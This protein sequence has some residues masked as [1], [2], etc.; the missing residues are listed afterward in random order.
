MVRVILVDLAVLFEVWPGAGADFFPDVLAALDQWRG[1]G[2]AVV[3]ISTDAS[4]YGARL[5]LLAEQSVP[6][7]DQPLPRW[8]QVG[9]WHD[10]LAEM[11]QSP[12][13][14]VF[15]AGSPALMASARQAGLHA[16]G[17][18]RDPRTMAVL[19]GLW[20]DGLADISW[21]RLQG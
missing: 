9:A 7:I 8:R 21:S 11:N 19:D 16:V 6:V 18:L 2:A 13:Q 3:G 10:V 1:M 4:R 5:S 12:E 15:V 14:C 20:V 17:V